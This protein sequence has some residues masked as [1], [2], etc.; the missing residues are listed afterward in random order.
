MNYFCECIDNKY[1]TS[2]PLVLFEQNLF[3]QDDTWICLDCLEHS[4]E[5][6]LPN[7]VDELGIYLSDSFPPEYQGES[8]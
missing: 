5:F 7:L 4:N 1:L 2:V 6:D 3:E 8:E